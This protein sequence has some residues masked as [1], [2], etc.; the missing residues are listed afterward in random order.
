MTFPRDLTFKKKAKKLDRWNKWL[1]AV[2]QRDGGVKMYTPQA[3]E[4]THLVFALEKK[5]TLC[6]TVYSDL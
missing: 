2:I 6:D 5:N 3:G 4:C 1:G